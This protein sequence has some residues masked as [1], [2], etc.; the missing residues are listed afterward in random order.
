MVIV[1]V[2]AIAGPALGAAS[3][4]IR[5]YAELQLLAEQSK[6]M[7][8]IMQQSEA[9]LAKLERRLDEPLSSQDLGTIVHAIATNMLQDV[10]GWARMFRVKAID[11]G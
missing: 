3:V 10:D 9:S 6:H 5:A 8:R 1:E 4:G 7:E 2:L 11:A